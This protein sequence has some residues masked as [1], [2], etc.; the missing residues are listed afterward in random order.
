MKIW[1]SK[2]FRKRQTP[3]P[4]VTGELP[5][6]EKLENINKPA[7]MITSSSQDNIEI[8]VSYSNQGFVLKVRSG[9]EMGGL[10]MKDIP[11]PVPSQLKNRAIRLTF[12]NAK[13]KPLQQLKQPGVGLATTLLFRLEDHADITASAAKSAILEA[14]HSFLNECKISDENP[15]VE[16]TF[17]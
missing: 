9:N 7:N 15:S 3:A 10:D 14:A 11:L 12:N 5:S 16:I 4:S 17:G 6:N 1:L 13:P 2:I 8:M